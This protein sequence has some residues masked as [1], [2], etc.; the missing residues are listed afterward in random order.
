MLKELKETYTIKQ[1]KE[2]IKRRDKEIED[3]KVECVS[4][5]RK[6]EKLCFCNS[7]GNQLNERKKLNKI[8]EIAVDNIFAL[9]GDLAIDKETKSAKIKELTTTPIEISSINKIN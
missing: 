9:E 1:L 6:I 2:I 7:Y 5:F 8:H 3:I 4:E